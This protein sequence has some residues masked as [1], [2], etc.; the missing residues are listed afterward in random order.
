[1]AVPVFNNPVIMLAF[2]LGFTLLI[3][4][5]ANW[6]LN[7]LTRRTMRRLEKEVPVPER[8][9]RLKT[10]VY[11]CR[12]VIFI[13]LLAVFV[14]ITLNSFGINIA[15]VLTGAG[16]AG[17]ALT[18]GAQTLIKDF[19]NGV[20]ILIEGQFSVGDTIQVGAFSGE[21]ERITLRSTS[22]RD[23]DGRLHSIPNGEIRALSNLTSSWS[24]AVVDLHLPLETDIEQAVA[25]LEKALEKLVSDPAIN[26]LLLEAPSVTGWTA[27]K[28]WA[29][30]VRLIVK[31]LPG[32]Q[33]VVSAALR[34]IAI[35]TL[36]E[37]GIEAGLSRQV[38]ELRRV[39]D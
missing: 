32:K 36:K 29:I 2:Q 34:K 38:V 25:V 4:L 31:T 18:L 28:D 14:L 26:G 19:L 24:R 39:S 33:Y 12:S 13:L 1:M 10:I 16:I 11:I 9:G 17:L 6:L 27:L 30:Q 3:F 22:L 15:P 21:V 35:E 23:L 7:L 20:L 5:A 37:V 8:L